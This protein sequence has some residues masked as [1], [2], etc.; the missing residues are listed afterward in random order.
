M[1]RA[2]FTL[3]LIVSIFLFSTSQTQPKPEATYVYIC[4]G[5]SSVCY[6][7]TKDCKGLTNCKS[8]IKKITKTEAEKLKRR[9]CKV[10]Y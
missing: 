5:G 8:E 1:K 3:S 2:I 10:C 9:P 4:T 6:H 7:K